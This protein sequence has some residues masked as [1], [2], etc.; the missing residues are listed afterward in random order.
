MA[1][2]DLVF[3]DMP[4]MPEVPRVPSYFPD[5]VSGVTSAGGGGLIALALPAFVVG[6]IGAGIFGGYYYYKNYYNPA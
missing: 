4:E 2:Q 1:D 5:L 6:L 3:N